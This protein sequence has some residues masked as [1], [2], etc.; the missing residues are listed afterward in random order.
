MKTLYIIAMVTL[1]SLSLHAELN[2]NNTWGDITT[3]SNHYAF[4]PS[5]PLNGHQV[6]V[7]EL[8]ATKDQFIARTM[9]TV[10]TEK[11]DWQEGS[12]CQKYE[13]VHLAIP[14]VIPKTICQ[15]ELNWQE[16]RLCQKY[17]TYYIKVPTTY[18]VGVYK[19]YGDSQI[20]D[21]SKPYTI[22]SCQ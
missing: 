17:K 22:P 8:C 4:F 9:V 7:N 5:L 10:C 18:T 3:S 15:E 21:F 14:K 19:V 11:L 13:K 16:D 20:Y 6:P 1:L 2:V 12:L